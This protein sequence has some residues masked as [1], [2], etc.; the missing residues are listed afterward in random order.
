MVSTHRFEREPKGLRASKF[1]LAL[2]EKACR[3]YRSESCECDS[4]QVNPRALG[5]AGNVKSRGGRKPA[6]PKD[7][8][9]PLARVWHA[10]VVRRAAFSGP[11]LAH[12]GW[13]S[14]LMDPCM[15]TVLDMFLVLGF[16]HVE[17]VFAN[18]PFFLKHEW[19]FCSFH[20]LAPRQN[21]S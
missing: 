9:E 13:F 5:N 15:R 11:L 17:Q 16:V 21:L 14:S 1:K 6:P 7:L 8:Q 20:L 12:P 4:D 3:S 10:Q 19:L 2:I 18:T